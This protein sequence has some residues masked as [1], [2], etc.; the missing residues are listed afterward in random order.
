MDYRL[1]TGQWVEAGGVP[2]PDK[3]ISDTLTVL[4]AAKQRESAE[5]A[6]ATPEYIL[7]NVC[8][9]CG[10]Q[11][12]EHDPT[13]CSF[14]PQL[15]E[16]IGTTDSHRDYDDIWRFP[17]CGQKYVGGFSEGEP[18]KS[19]GCVKGRHTPRYYHHDKRTS[20]ATVR[21]ETPRL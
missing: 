17:C 2:I 8:S 11:Y 16:K 14:H 15:P 1:C 9:R 10:A 20:G 21:G 18:P 19:P 7:L 3:V 6:A 13:G 4:D 5:A 12:G